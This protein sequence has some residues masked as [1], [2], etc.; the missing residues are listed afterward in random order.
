VARVDGRK[1][2]FDGQIMTMHPQTYALDTTWRT[3]LK[4]LGVAL[5]N[6]LRRA[7]LADD[8]LQQP[9]VRLAPEDYYRFWDSIEAETGDPLFPIRLCRVI[10]SESFSPPLFAAL[11]SPNFLVAAQRIARYKTLVA[12]MRLDVAEARDI[13]TIELSWLDAPLTPPVSLVITELLFFASLAR[14]GTREPVRPV[15]VVSTVLPSPTA[16]YEEFLGARIQRGAKPRLT[17]TNADATRPFLTSNEP[18]WAAFEPELRHRLAELDASVT[19][20]KRVRAALLEGLP[21]GLLTMEA[22]AR[23]LAL[24][25][26]TLQRRIEA[27]GTSYQRILQETREALARHYLQKTLLPAAEIAFLLGFDEPNSFYRAFRPWTGTTPDSVRQR[28]SPAAS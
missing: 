7:G 13:V 15:E 17:F 5:A 25:K 8:L 24:S 10:R 9:S 21:S 4:D 19:T 20:A 26:R 28:S 18:M 11:C 27:E 16:P 23:K 22:I 14:M 3:L 1:A 6:V 12:P 2:P